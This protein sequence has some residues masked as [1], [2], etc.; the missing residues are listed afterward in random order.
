MVTPRETWCSRFI[1]R[2][3]VPGL[4][5]KRIERQKHQNI[6]A[7]AHPFARKDCRFADQILDL[8]ESSAG[9]RPTR[10]RH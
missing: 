5:D 10:L 6:M 4:T 3:D 2:R 9:Y 7:K 1:Q 8:Q